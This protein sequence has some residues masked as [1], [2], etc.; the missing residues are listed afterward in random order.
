MI[1]LDK[2]IRVELYNGVFSEYYGDD[3]KNVTFMDEFTIC[4]GNSRI[5]IMSMLENELHGFEIKSEHDNLYRLPNQVKY[6]QKVFD[7]LTLVCH[8][9]HYEKA[10]DII[11]NEW[12]IIL[13]DKNNEFDI[14]KESENNSCIDKKSLIQLLWKDELKELLEINN[15]L[16]GFKSKNKRILRSRVDEIVEINELKNYLIETI[17]TREYY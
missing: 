14:V 11:P 2:D 17:K 5:D 6:Y 3:I 12:G 4:N 9:K 10:L 1:L 13:I 8:N 15:S 16:K 7:K